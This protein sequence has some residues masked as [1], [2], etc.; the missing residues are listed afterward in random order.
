MFDKDSRYRYNKIS[1]TL[2]GNYAG[3]QGT[4]IRIIPPTQGTFIH[5]VNQ[6]E[7]LDILGY[8]YYSKSGAWWRICDAN[9]DISY[10]GDCIDI[11]PTTKEH[12]V[13]ESPAFFSKREQL[14]NGLKT[15]GTTA[16]RTNTMFLVGDISFLDKA[17]SLP[18]NN[19]SSD[20]YWGIQVAALFTDTSFPMA[21]L[22]SVIT[23]A[24][25]H[26]RE[27]RTIAHT[28]VRFNIM[29]CDDRET[30]ERWNGLIRALTKMIGVNDVTG[31]ASMSMINIMYNSRHCTRES[32][33]STA[34][35]W[36]FEATSDSWQES[37]RGSAL[38]I[39]PLSPQRQK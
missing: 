6:H 25:L 31:D 35:S 24:G 11:A 17:E 21:K 20:M 5:H 29:W 8:R 22:I 39:P 26:V 13:F 27:T 16:W 36:G 4:Q 32:L 30:L 12:F 9:P 15:L 7:R 37:P 1:P 33:I 2:S 28:P 38:V 18:S 34:Q 10:P 14:F 3:V 19:P 23:A